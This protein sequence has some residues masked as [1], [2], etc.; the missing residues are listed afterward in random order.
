MLA[1]VF[2]PRLECIRPKW[3]TR[4]RKTGQSWG[5]TLVELMVII[6]VIAI[7]AIAAMPSYRA[8]MDNY[9]VR[10][11]GEDVVSLVVNAR[12]AA[13]KLHRPVNV[14]F[15]TGAS[16]CTGANSAAAPAGGARA[17]NASACDCTTPSGCMV[18]AEQ[19]AIP[20]GK[21]P[22][23]TMSAASNGLVFDGVT[24]ASVGLVGSTITLDSPLSMYTATVTV[25]PLG[26]ASLVVSE[27]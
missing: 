20:V 17:G 16:W 25:T 2:H 19:A 14:S 1:P 24:G 10:K 18:D 13:V 12:A 27:D 26:Q 9:R 23:V 6:A 3:G 4:V 7:L 11:A 15:A 21:H 5:F 22:G 8:L